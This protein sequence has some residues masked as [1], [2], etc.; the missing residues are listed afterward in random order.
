MRLLPDYRVFRVTMRATEIYKNR[1][2]QLPTFF[3]QIFQ[4]KIRNSQFL[5]YFLL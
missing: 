5:K 3:L 4:A 2:C 1:M